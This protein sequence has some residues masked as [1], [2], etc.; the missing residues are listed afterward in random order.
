MERYPK[1]WWLPDEVS[2][3]EMPKARMGKLREKEPRAQFEDYKR[4][5]AK[6]RFSRGGTYA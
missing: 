5:T 3:E 2:L 6:R 4:P 1:G